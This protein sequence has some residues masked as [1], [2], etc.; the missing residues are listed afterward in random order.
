M[1][2]M[3][4]IGA[5]IFCLISL[6]SQTVDAKSMNSKTN[7]INNNTNFEKYADSGKNKKHIDEDKKDKDTKK[8]VLKK[9][10]VQPERKKLRNRQKQVIPGAGKI[11]NREPIKIILNPRI[12]GV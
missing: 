10:D 4:L 5:F 3:S 8:S 11:K 7:E 12:R 2:I 9:R 6:A 1:K